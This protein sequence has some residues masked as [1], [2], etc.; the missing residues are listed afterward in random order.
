[1]GTKYFYNFCLTEYENTDFSGD[2]LSAVRKSF[3]HGGGRIRDRITVDSEGESV[4]YDYSLEKDKQLRWTVKDSHGE[5]LQEVVPAAEGRYHLCFYSGGSIVKR[6]LF[7]R[8]HTLLRAEYMDKSGAVCAS[9][10]PRK[11]P[12]GLCLLYTDAKLAEPVILSEMPEINDDR[13]AEK[14]SESFTDYSAVAFTDDGAVYYL[15]PSQ[16]K[17]FREFLSRAEEEIENEAEE[18]FI[19][20]D[21]PLFDQINVKDFNVKRNLSSALDIT[22]AAA[23]GEP[24]VEDAT[25][26]EASEDAEEPELDGGSIAEIAA[27]VINEIIGEDEPK[28]SDNAVKPDKEIIADGAVYSYFGELDD[29]GNRTGFGRTVTDLGITAYEGNYRNDKR[30]GKGAYYYKDG[31]LCYSGDW[32]E[33]ARHGVGVGISSR[34]GSF[35]VGR[36]VNN[37]PEGN[38]VRLSADGDIRFVCKE[39]SD[40]KTVLMNYQ[41]DDSVLI[42]KYDEQGKKISE[43]TVSLI[44]FE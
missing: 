41:S 30:S 24:P 39:L 27:A 35:H 6:L 1:M 15:S 40:G 32:A 34:D 4:F 2:I 13:V 10:E 22:M 7:S 44:D 3:L 8:M 21:T 26:D 16:E 37:K 25:S 12:G 33:N 42:S 38:G 36:W 17:S 11:A 20:D 9:I 28:T 18:S 19:G 29:K 14:V 31:S 5:L 23:F 43:K